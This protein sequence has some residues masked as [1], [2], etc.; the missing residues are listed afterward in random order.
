MIYNYYYYYLKF[1]RNASI[2]RLG[3]FSTKERKLE[4]DYEISEVIIHP[5]YRI[6]ESYN[7]IAIIKLKNKVTFSKHIKPVCMPADDETNYEGNHA[8]V[9]GWGAREFGKIT[10]LFLCDAT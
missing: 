2:V 3:S 6:T 4:N 7:D 5:S 8:K 10:N 1:F 9:I